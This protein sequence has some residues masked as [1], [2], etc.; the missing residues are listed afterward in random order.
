MQ[1]YSEQQFAYASKRIAFVFILNVI[2][3]GN[4]ENNSTHFIKWAIDKKYLSSSRTVGHDC[5]LIVVALYTVKV[6]Y[7]KFCPYGIT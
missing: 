6:S 3:L 2:T 4:L 1:M 7:I 5:P